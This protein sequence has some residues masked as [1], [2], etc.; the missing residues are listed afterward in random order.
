MHKGT[1]C[2][3]CVAQLFLLPDPNL[4]TS[5][6]ECAFTFLLLRAGFRPSSEKV[7]G[8]KPIQ[9]DIS[10]PESLSCVIPVLCDP[11]PELQP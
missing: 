7:S 8:G 11:C 10:I 1:G 5:C 4:A 6:C 9:T 2:F 3:S